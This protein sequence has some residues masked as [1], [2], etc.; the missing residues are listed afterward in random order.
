MLPGRGDVPLS[1]TPSR[2]LS[3]QQQVPAQNWRHPLQ[4]EPLPKVG[5][6]EG[7]PAPARRR[8]AGLWAEVGL[9]PLAW[10]HSALLARGQAPWAGTL[11]WPSGEPGSQPTPIPEQAHAE[12]LRLSAAGDRNKETPLF[13]SKWVC[14]DWG[15]A[16]I[17]GEESKKENK[18]KH[19]AELRSL[20]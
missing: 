4:S 17:G 8:A 14:L 19:W 13:P 1:G 15:E 12:D 16:G 3:A 18:N 7:S 2:G 11:G 5:G 10:A 6:R 20:C 9:L